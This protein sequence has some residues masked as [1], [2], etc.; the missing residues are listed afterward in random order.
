MSDRAQY[1]WHDDGAFNS[2]FE[3]TEG[4]SYYCDHTLHSVN[5]LLQEYVQW[6]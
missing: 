2:Q 4:D 5:L 1:L 6:L 3:I